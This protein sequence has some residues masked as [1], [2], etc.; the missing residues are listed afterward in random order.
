MLD[1][2]TLELTSPRV[3]ARSPKRVGSSAA[4]PRT[5]A[6]APSALVLSRDG[7]REMSRCEFPL[8]VRSRDRLTNCSS[9]RD[10]NQHEQQLTRFRFPMTEHC[11]TANSAR[12]ALFSTITLLPLAL[13]PS[14]NRR[15][16][17]RLPLLRPLRRT[18][19]HH[20]P[21]SRGRKRSRGW[22]SKFMK[23]SRKR[24]RW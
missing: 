2:S 19:P 20:Q 6:C 17:R 16:A 21:S 5:T 13:L 9:S 11:T 15:V 8:Q 23:M 1:R 18:L 7:R 3:T 14:P 10:I 12:I 24:R 4:E 22:R